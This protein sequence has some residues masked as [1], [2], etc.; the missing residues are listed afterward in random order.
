MNN[1]R[2]QKKK[3]KSI[4]FTGRALRLFDSIKKFSIKNVIRIAIISE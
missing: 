4:V 3:Y 2:E 1:V